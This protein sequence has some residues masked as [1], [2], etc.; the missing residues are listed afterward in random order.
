[1]NVLELQAF[2]HKPN[3]CHPHLTYFHNCSCRIQLPSLMTIVT[4]SRTQPRNP[5]PFRQSKLIWILKKFA[6]LLATLKRCTTA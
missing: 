3:G 2:G 4:K 1:M 5:P 6:L